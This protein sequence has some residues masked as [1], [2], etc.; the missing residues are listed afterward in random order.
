[1]RLTRRPLGGKYGKPGTTFE[2][3]IGGS[4]ED[5][6]ARGT[7]C[8]P[9]RESRF[10]TPY[11]V[12]KGPGRDV[13]LQRARF[14][15]GVTAS[16]D[17]FEFYDDWTRPGNAHR[18]LEEPWLGYILFLEEDVKH[19][20]FQKPRSQPRGEAADEKTWKVESWAD[21]E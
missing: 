5:S 8:I 15:F 10:F 6:R 16:G 18:V 2:G 12:A 19:L 13:S 3:E 21:T 1:M 11:R 4:D 17:K 20:E 9:R 14:T 7:G